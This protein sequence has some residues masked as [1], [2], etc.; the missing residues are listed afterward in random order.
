MTGFTQ[1]MLAEFG[2]R[3]N[4][5]PP[6][7]AYF[8]WIESKGLD[9]HFDGSEGYRHALLD[10]SL[11]ESCMGIVPQDPGHAAA[12]V[13]IDTA[14]VRERLVPFCK[15]GGDGSY[16]ALWVD[17]AGVTQIVHLGS[18]SGSTMTGV[19]VD[20][21][22]DFLRLLAIGY[23]ELCWPEVHHLSPLQAHYE[24]HPRE[25]YQGMEDEWPAPPPV[26]EALRAWIAEAYNVEIPDR[27]SKIIGSLPD[28]MD[29]NSTDPFV[30]WLNA[31]DAQ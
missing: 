19:M 23:D 10:P 27:A 22:V 15:T 21:P 16:A 2:P 17:E 1:A 5:P 24:E 8:E 7:H 3:V 30:Q 26:P 13:G 11:A 31:V 28:M 29:E 25:D 6:V 20:D 14:E 4:V 9:R 18:G 12:W